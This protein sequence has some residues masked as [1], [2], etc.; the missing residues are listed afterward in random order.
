MTITAMRAIDRFLG[1]PLC[2]IS[3]IVHRMTAKPSVVHVRSILVI[4]FF[5]LGSILL[6][7]PT[8]QSLRTKYPHSRIVLLSFSQNEELL[9][10]IP[11]V[12]EYW[13]IDPRSFASFLT[14]FIR[15]FVLLLTSNI[16]VVL[17]LEFFSKFSTLVG[18]LARPSMHV[19][20][21]LPTRWR[22]WNLTHPI[23]F[24]TNQHVTMTF[25]DTLSP[26]GISSN[27]TL[28]PSL[29]ASGGRS[30]EQIVDR[31][32][33]ERTD[34][35]CINP[36]AGRTSLDRRWSRNRFAQTAAILR[37]EIPTA[38]FCFTGAPGEREYVQSI[39]ARIGGGPDRIVNLAGRLSLKELIALFSEAS[40]LITNDSGPMHLAAAVD[41]PTVAI[42]GPES[43]E[44][45]GPVGNSSINLYASLPCSPCLNVYDAK[46]FICPI[47]QQ[48]LRSISVEEIVA[49][50]RILM[51]QE[52]PAP[53]MEAFA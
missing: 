28:R 16:D 4:K 17:D 20:F 47:Q 11:S 49:A 1:V 29:K 6:A 41:L 48:C 51:E 25:R 21:A 14:S 10:L 44:F 23:A 27:R 5:G 53:L 31:S 35:I 22:V 9:P 40:M 38:L 18:A 26:F 37:K 15:V 7:T 46:K 12:D 52:S 8:L 45:Y 30:T 42:F 24:R 19:G 2:W 36:N 3:G 32:L 43:P 13:L 33:N 34:I 39:I 50:A